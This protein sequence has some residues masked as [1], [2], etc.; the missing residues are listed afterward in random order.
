MPRYRL[1][2]PNPVEFEANSPTEIIRHLWRQ[3][4]GRGALKD[5][6]DWRVST[7]ENHIRNAGWWSG[8]SFNTETNQTFVNDMLNDGLLVQTRSRQFMGKLTTVQELKNKSGEFEFWLTLQ[9]G[10][11]SSGRHKYAFE[12]IKQ[13]ARLFH[14]PSISDYDVV[15]TIYSGFH[16]RLNAELPRRPDTMTHAVLESWAEDAL[17]ALYGAGKIKTHRSFTWHGL[18]PNSG[19]KTHKNSVFKVRSA[20]GFFR[21]LAINHRKHTKNLEGHRFGLA[22]FVRGFQSSFENYLDFPT[23]LTHDS[24]LFELVMHNFASED[25]S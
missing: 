6:D 21:S 1:N 4:D 8:G 20:T 22:A 17:T 7:A 10:F 12:A 13:A 15:E 19:S 3:L 9:E 25:L 14:G 5:L 24:F 2:L 11:L 23:G 18:N 16:H